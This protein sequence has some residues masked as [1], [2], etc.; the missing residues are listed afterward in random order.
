MV[1]ASS[2]LGQ[3]VVKIEI[4]GNQ[5]T[6][7]QAIRVLLRL[8][9]GQTLNRSILRQDVQRI[10]GFGRFSDV[11]VQGEAVKGGVAITFLVKEKPSIREIRFVGNKE[12]GETDVKG[13][14]DLKKFGILDLAKVKR[15]S[16]RSR[17]STLKRGFIS[18]RFVLRSPSRSKPRSL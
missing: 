5:R 12:L 17:T 10:F 11:T 1:Q 18:Q 8:K 15:T 13:V 3:K 9:V 16:K 7:T 6:E 4:K 2:L 14:V